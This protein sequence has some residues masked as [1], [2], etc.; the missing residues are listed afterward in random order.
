[1]LL[2]FADR[3][4]AQALEGFIPRMKKNGRLQKGMNADIVVFYPETIHAVVT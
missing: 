4:A 1:M 2:H 3:Y